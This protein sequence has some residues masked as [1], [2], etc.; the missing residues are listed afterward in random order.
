MKLKLSKKNFEAVL[1][2][3]P[4]FKDGQKKFYKVIK[5]SY[6]YS[7]EVI[8]FINALHDNG[9]IQPFD[10]MPWQ[11]NAEKILNHPKAIKRADLKIIIKVLT[12][13]IKKERRNQGYLFL[14]IGNGQLLAILKRIEA[15]YQTKL[16]KR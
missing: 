3:M 14:V 10:W 5:G 7:Q 16:L 2:Y 8:S 15:I 9:F 12:I 11:E 13:L 4:Y 6:S 1:D